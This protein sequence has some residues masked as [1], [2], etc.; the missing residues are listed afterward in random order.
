ME[1][2]RSVICKSQVKIMP[3]KLE[4]SSRVN[5]CVVGC[6]HWGKNLARNFCDLG[7]LH[8][9]CESSRERLQSFSERYPRPN[10][11]LAWKT[12]WPI[13]NWTAWQSPLRRKNITGWSWRRSKPANMYLS[14]SR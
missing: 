13:P 9:I 8:S 2:I 6:G 14:K 11:V 7:H 3:S 5:L 12:R 1:L 4:A 10:L